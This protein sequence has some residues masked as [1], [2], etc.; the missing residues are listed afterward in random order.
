MV[1]DAP[2]SFVRHILRQDKLRIDEIEPALRKI[3]ASYDINVDVFQKRRKT[4]W[5]HLNEIARNTNTDPLYVFHYMETFRRKKK[6][7]NFSKPRDGELSIP[8]RY[9][10]I[11]HHI[12]GDKMS[13]IEEVSKRCFKFYSHL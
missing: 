9:I 5:Q 2:H 7:D 3:A 8:E 11:Y 10:Q 12:G 1:L 13:T 4:K 6:W